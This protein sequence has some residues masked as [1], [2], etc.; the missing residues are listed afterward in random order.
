MPQSC[1]SQALG[2][3]RQRPGEPTHH[4]RGRL[5]PRQAASVH[6]TCK[7]CR[8]CD[9]GV[10]IVC[11]GAVAAAELRSVARHHHDENTHTQTSTAGSI[12]TGE[13]PARRQTSRQVRRSGC[14]DETRRWCCDVLCCRVQQASEQRAVE[15]HRTVSQTV[16]QS[17]R[18]ERCYYGER[19]LTAAAGSSPDTWCWLAVDAPGP[20]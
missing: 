5:R 11:E 7:C 16:G 9:G 3:S 19:P 13:R 8:P 20:M 18:G 1:R 17:A 10:C 4:G 6:G 2:C 15:A 14:G 12:T